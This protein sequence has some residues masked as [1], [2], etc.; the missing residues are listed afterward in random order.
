MS[1]V[2]L[3]RAQR[4]LMYI[5][6]KNKITYYVT[7]L[8]VTKISTSSMM[9]SNILYPAQGALTTSNLEFSRASLSS[10]GS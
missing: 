9:T 10:W 7:L 4:I 8:A 3:V 1:F 5:Y 6:S 2:V